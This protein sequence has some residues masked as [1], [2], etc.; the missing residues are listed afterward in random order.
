MGAV[1]LLGSQLVVMVTIGCLTIYPVFRGMFLTFRTGEL[2]Q[3]RGYARIGNFLML[4]SF[5]GFALGPVLLA[6]I[7]HL[8]EYVVGP[9]LGER[10]GASTFPLILAVSPWVIAWLIGIIPSI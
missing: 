1:L 7:G 10:H 4:W 8:F 5:F 9:M 2:L 3:Y 6:G